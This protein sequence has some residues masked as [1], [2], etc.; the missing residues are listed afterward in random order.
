M[1][2]KTLTNDDRIMKVLSRS[3]VAL[4]TG[5]IAILSEMN[6]WNCELSLQSLEEKD[7]VECIKEKKGIFWR[8]K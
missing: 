2:N 7:L 3:K 5:K 4:S 8:I 1:K 6:Y